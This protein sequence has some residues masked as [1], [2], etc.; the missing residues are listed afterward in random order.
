MNGERKHENLATPGSS[1]IK[2]VVKSISILNSKQTKTEVT[3]G[4]IA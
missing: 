1:Q 2:D 4:D 3:A